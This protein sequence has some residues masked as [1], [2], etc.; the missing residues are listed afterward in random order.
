MCGAIGKTTLGDGNKN[1][2]FY[3]IIRDCDA[4]TSADRMTRIAKLCSRWIM[5]HGF[6]FGI[7]DVMPT[8]EILEAKEREIAAAYAKCDELIRAYKEGRLE[9]VAGCDEDL[10]LEQQV[11]CERT[12]RFEQQ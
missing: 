10:S 7:E 12:G 4:E 8:K 5:L 1:S 11:P 9:R 6:T 2:L 3:S